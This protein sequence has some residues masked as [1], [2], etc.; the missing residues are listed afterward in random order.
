MADGTAI[1]GALVEIYAAT[2]TGPV[3]GVYTAGTYSKVNDIN[4]I[5]ASS[6]RPS[7]SQGVFMR[8]TQYTTYGQ[9]EQ[10]YTVSGF[11][12]IG[13]T[14]QGII[15]TA[16]EDNSVIAIKVLRDATNGW[17]QFVRVGSKRESFAPEGL[18]EV[19]YDLGAA[20]ARTLVGTG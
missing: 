8:T 20:S 4:R 7:T 19:S 17:T 2:A 1:D 6:N 10:P 12:S 15:D 18:Q 3:A 16:H 9:R 5:D 11:K 14:G 13:D